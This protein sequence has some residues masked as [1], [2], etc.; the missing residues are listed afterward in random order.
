MD[1]DDR[2]QILTKQVTLYDYCYSIMHTLY[3]LTQHQ[4]AERY[5]RSTQL[6]MHI[7]HFVL[8]DFIFFSHIMWNLNPLDSDQSS[9]RTDIYLA[10]IVNADVYRGRHFH[11]S[12]ERKKEKRG[13]NQHSLMRKSTGLRVRQG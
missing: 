5:V 4:S 3:S 9:T 8:F 2:T 10:I 6:I 12:K 7:F 11:F 1:T 13:V